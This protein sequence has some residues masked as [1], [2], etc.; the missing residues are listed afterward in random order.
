MLYP[1]WL[2][3]N[4]ENYR[5]LLK[6]FS[7][8]SDEKAVWSG[9]FSCKNAATDGDL[10]DLKKKYALDR[11]AYNRSELDTCLKAME[12][13]F[14][15]LLHKEFREFSGKLHAIEILEFS[16]VNRVTLNCL[17][18]ATILTEVL[19][20]LGFKARTISCLPIDVA[21]NDNHVITTVFITGLGKWVM[22]DPSLCCYITD[23]NKTMLSIPE[24]RRSLIDDSPLEVCLYSRFLNTKSPVSGYS[25]FDKTEYLTYLYKNFFRFMACAV[26]GADPAPGDDIFYQ[27]VPDGYLAHNTEQKNG[28]W[29]KSITIRITNNA[30]FFW[31]DEAHEEERSDV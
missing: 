4:Y 28:L 14:C 12:W 19:L 31:Y 13:T 27:L 24:I 23:K 22:L 16:V 1:E 6:K 2:R 10:R 11:L 5:Y 3:A 25:S 7:A 17:C 9:S 29:E 18:H 26:Q 8:Y 30:G 15:R 20:A 21:P